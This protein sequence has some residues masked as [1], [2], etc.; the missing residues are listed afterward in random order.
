MRPLLIR[1][2]VLPL[3]RRNVDT[4]LIVPAS[5][6][7]TVSRDGLGEGCFAALR[8][9]PGNPFEDPRYARAPILAAGA[10][11]GC[12]SSRE[13]AVWA[14]QQIGIRAVLA[15]SFGE[16]FEG[17]A[18]RNG[19]LAIRLPEAEVAALMEFDAAAHVTIDLAE[20]RLILPDG[21]ALD[22]EIDPFRKRCLIEGLDD[23]AVTLELEPAIA[24]Y[25][26]RATAERPWTLPRTKEPSP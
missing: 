15:P 22:F 18:L 11:F 7:K 26:A 13:H 16:I 17:N 24:A 12:G 14:L 3:P 10:N 2:A 20:Q 21:R 25:E 1:G 4:D 19:L 8:G 9:E 23:V 6:M 5:Y